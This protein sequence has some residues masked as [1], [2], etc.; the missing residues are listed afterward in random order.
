MNNMI[1]DKE[2]CDIAISVQKQAYAPYSKFRVGAALL[3]KDG[4]IYTGCNIENAS[5]GA[6]ICAERCAVSKAVSDGK[7]DFLKIA[8]T[9]SS[10]EYTM[11]CGIC[12]Q[13]LYEFMKEGIVVVTNGQDI[14]RYSVEELIP[15]CFTL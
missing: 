8:I 9:S 4:S 3:C 1:S 12:R 15:G 11:P 13:V 2:L 5:Y 7:R 14:K 6:T 10:N